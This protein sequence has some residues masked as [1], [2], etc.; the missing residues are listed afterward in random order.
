MDIKSTLKNLLTETGSL[1]GESYDEASGLLKDTFSKIYDVKDLTKEKLTST[2]NDLI[3]LAPLIE[4]A[5]Y[6]T[7][8]ISIG[9]SVPPKVTFHFEK[10]ANISKEDIQILL[11][12]NSSNMLLKIIVNT[13]ISTDDFQSKLNIGTFKFSEIDIELGVPPQV[14]VKLV[15]PVN[16]S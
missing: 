6:R 3:A 5:G 2:A 11:E 9:V 13:L 7:K 10:F 14:N 12:N 8:E 1:V 15:N 4:Q 16:N